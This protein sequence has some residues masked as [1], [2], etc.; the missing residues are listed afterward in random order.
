MSNLKLEMVSDLKSRPGAPFVNA[1]RA[2]G[3]LLLGLMILDMSAS[4]TRTL[5]D[6]MTRYAALVEAVVRWLKAMSL[7]EMLLDNFYVVIQGFNSN[8][9]VTLVDGVL[10]GDL[11]IDALE[12]ELLSIKLAGA[13]PIGETMSAALDMIQSKKREWNLSGIPYFEPMIVLISDDE[14]NGQDDISAAAERVDAL[15]E[16]EKLVLLPVGIGSEGASFPRLSRFVQAVGGESAVVSSR[17][18]LRLFFRFLNQTVP[19]LASGKIKLS[20]YGSW[21]SNWQHT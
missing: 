14:E 4:M 13:T 16:N 3:K 10:L 1:A 7:D 18:D 5:P 8:G 2:N 20:S 12:Q 9:T 11:D 15:L 6:G 17:D 19:A 21:A